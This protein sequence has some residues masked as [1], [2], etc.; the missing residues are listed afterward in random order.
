MARTDRFR[1]EHEQLLDMA[2]QLQSHLD[3]VRLAADASAA[4]TCLGKLMGRLVLHLATEDKVLYPEFAASQD[5]KVA[6]IGRRFASEMASTVPLVTAYNDKWATPS[7]IKRDP[8]A[9]IAETRKILSVLAD[10][11]RRENQE[12]YATAD[13]AE[14]R[15]F[16]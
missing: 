4:R 5:P 10:R 9:F 1:A 7:A 6:A 16:A 8:H 11:I 14:G 12:L 15:A 13:Q 3:P 2:R